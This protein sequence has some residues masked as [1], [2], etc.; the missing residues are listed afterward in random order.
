MADYDIVNTEK[1]AAVAAIDQLLDIKIKLEFDLTQTKKKKLLGLSV[2]EKT[3]T[4]VAHTLRNLKD[5]LADPE[6]YDPAE[7]PN[8]QKYL[9]IYDFSQI[10]TLL[11]TIKTHCGKIE[12]YIFSGFKYTGYF[13]GI[14]IMVRGYM[15]RVT[16]IQN[17]ISTMNAE[18]NA[19]RTAQT[20][21]NQLD[22]LT[23]E[24][25]NFKSRVIETAANFEGLETGAI[26]I[27]KTKESLYITFVNM[28]QGDC[29][30]IKTPKGKCIMIDCGESGSS[31]PHNG[32]DLAKVK[33]AI[34]SAYFL[35]TSSTIDFLILTHPDE[36]HH[37]R[38]TK[39]FTDDIPPDPTNPFSITA[40]ASKKKGPK[41]PK[42]SNI[43]IDTVFHSAAVG[44]YGTQAT[45]GAN[46]TH[47]WLIS[48]KVKSRYEIAN[49][50]SYL[51]NTLANQVT[52][53][54][55]AFPGGLPVDPQGAIIIYN[56]PGNCTISVLASNVLK[57]GVYPND[58][59]TDANRGSVVTLIECHGKKIIIGGDA[60]VV[61][62]TF[63]LNRYEGSGK[64]KDVNL[65]T[66]SHHGSETSSLTKYVSHIQPKAVVV[67]AGYGNQHGLPKKEIIND[68]FL[69]PTVNSRIVV[70]TPHNYYYYSGTGLNRVLNDN[71]G[72]GINLNKQLSV[73]GM[74]GNIYYAIRPDSRAIPSPFKEVP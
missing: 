53:T 29:A 70:D 45:V 40:S 68:R 5:I 61:T 18:R 46:G 4:G 57:T 44:S 34:Q 43:K 48:S 23:N 12:T 64:I 9:F 1:D 58:N 13:T 71:N 6:K 49:Y 3:F 17:A 66:T 11:T 69:K 21:T 27:D 28:E 30:L 72:N 42:F 59:S 50:D 62:E 24:I 20:L 31:A 10:N 19:Q 52:V 33:A 60:T 55:P 38:L 73:T 7:A 54:N 37:N 36:D 26:V 56:E 15:A 67:S 39:I 41:L 74:S 47:A 2:T 8:G 14:E 65:A 51:G 35:G 32:A 22:L 25:T 16:N 63:L